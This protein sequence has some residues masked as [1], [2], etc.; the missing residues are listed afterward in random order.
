MN[1]SVWRLQRG[2]SVRSHK[3]ATVLGPELSLVPRE[4]PMTENTL[5]QVTRFRLSCASHWDKTGTFIGRRRPRWRKRHVTSMTISLN[6]RSIHLIAPR[7][8]REG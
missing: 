6:I 2:H 8:P 5:A 3:T 4:T 7:S 1:L